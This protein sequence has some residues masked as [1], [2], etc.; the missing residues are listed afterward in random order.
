MTYDEIMK[1]TDVSEKE[2]QLK[3]FYID[4][5]GINEWLKEDNTQ[6]K[7]LFKDRVEYKKM[8]VL[9]NLNG[10]SIEYENGDKK[11]YINGEMMEKEEWKKISTPLLRELKLTRV[12]KKE[13]TSK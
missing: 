5:I 11:Y 6:Q 13:S 12:L 10:A 9:H 4:E 3:K 1:L 7:I 8:G 2:E